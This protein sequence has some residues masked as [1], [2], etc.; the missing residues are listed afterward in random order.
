MSIGDSFVGR[1]PR[2]DAPHAPPR[3]RTDRLEACLECAAFVGGAGD[4]AARHRPDRREI[5]RGVARL[6]APGP[7]RTTLVATGVRVGYRARPCPCCRRP[8]W[9]ERTVVERTVSEGA[10][11]DEA[12]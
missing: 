6:S 1:R 5:E 8:G 2:A 3:A 12:E 11:D 4:P 7:R 10:E 9:G